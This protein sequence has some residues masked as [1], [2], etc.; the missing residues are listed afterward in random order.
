MEAK[1][2]GTEQATAAGESKGKLPTDTGKQRKQL[3][4]RRDDG[5]IDA[6]AV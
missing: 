2:R 4:R 6:A 1:L 5:L 3:R